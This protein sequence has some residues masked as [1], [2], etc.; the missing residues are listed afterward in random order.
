MSTTPVTLGPFEL[1]DVL[2]RGGMGVVYEAVHT[3]TG[4]SVAI[5]VMIGDRAADEQYRAD[6]RAE[7][8]AVAGLDHPGIVIVLDLGEVTEEA[9]A[10]MPGEL[11]EGS[12]W[13]A[14]E[15]ASMGTLHEVAR[16]LPWPQLRRTL[17]GLLDA[18][19]HAHSRGIVHRDMKPANVLL[20][21]RGHA[22]SI[23]A[24]GRSWDGAVR[25]TDFGLAH[26]GEGRSE[27]GN[28]ELTTA[29]TPQYMA[30]E[31]FKGHW[32]DYGPWTDLYA[33]GC[34]AWELA[35][36]RL[37]FRGDS[38][39]ALAYAHTLGDR[40]EWPAELSDRLPPGLHGWIAKLM[41]REPGDRFQRA[42]DAAWALTRLEVPEELWE[43]LPPTGRE[44][45]SSVATLAPIG[46]TFF[47][48]RS[49]TSSPGSDL[50]DALGLG[51]AAA[52]GAAAALGGA[53]ARIETVV[54]DLDFLDEP[55][56]ATDGLP[57]MPPSWRRPVATRPS[58]KL[59]GAGLGL[60]GLRAIPMVGRRAA[61]DQLWGALAD[62]RQTGR[63]RV[64]LLHGPAGTGK[65]RLAGW[66]GR[67]AEEVGAATLLRAAHGPIPGADHGAEA[68]LC[69]YLRCVGMDRGELAERLA[70]M[71]AAAGRADDGEAREL[72]DLLSPD[73][74]GPTSLR[75][76]TA[77]REALARTVSRIAS[78]RPV[79]LI[80]DDVAYSAESIALAERLAG[81]G[82]PV[83]VL[84]T[85]RDEALAGR[86]TETAALDALLRLD[87]T[88]R[89]E[90][91]PL[92]EG[93][94]QQLVT[95]LLGFRTGLAAAIDDRTGGNPLFCTA[96]IGDWVARG[97][98]VPGET[99]FELR[100]GAD[101]RL[102]DDLYELASARL[103]RITDGLDAASD[104]ALEA[105][106]ALGV[107][108]DTGE[109]TQVCLD[110]ELTAP[111]GSLL[112]RLLDGA[113]AH[114]T[115]RGWAFANAMLPESL[116]RRARETGGWP[117]LNLACAEMLATS[118]GPAALPERVGLHL[119]AADELEAAL[120]PLLEGARRCQGRSDPRGALALLERRG[121]AE[122]VLGL[123][124][125]DERRAEG[126]AVRAWAHRALGELDRAE[127]LAAR[128]E[129]AAPGGPSAA[130]AA[131]VRAQVAHARGD[132]D[133]SRQEHQ[134]A[135]LLCRDAGLE[136]EATQAIQGLADLALRGGRA[137][138]A[139]A[140]FERAGALFARLGQTVLEADCLRAQALATLRLGDPAD[141]TERLREALR[142]YEAAGNRRGMAD[143]LNSLA[144]IAR[145]QG[146]L[147][148]AEDGYR[149]ALGLHQATGVGG[150]LARINLGLV[151]L[152]QE[153]FPEAARVLASTL[154]LLG[155]GGRRA[156]VACA[157]AATVACRAA[158]RDWS[159]FD[160][161]LDRART[162]LRE[163]DTSER[164]VAVVVEQAGR[165]AAN[166]GEAERAAEAWALAIEQWRALGDTDRAARLEAERATL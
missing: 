108:V 101:D 39:F 29:G 41:A 132:F 113:L 42:A 5:K 91:G 109:W 3:P 148:D 79:V 62:V 31:Q 60:Y 150:E 44:H 164:D 81:T 145:K 73:P 140:L 129:D 56:G 57:P 1:R 52:V 100:P 72:L 2:G 13:M 103:A 18:L 87:R 99:G 151:L 93:D 118:A 111:L 30:P 121:G 47:V 61:R 96:L 165:I 11:V 76:A 115:P 66:L 94:R 10:A 50:A 59:V 136:Q 133:R 134:R 20:G 63:P 45:H 58:T 89:I 37:P 123:S 83:L 12:P 139:L 34:M 158:E 36:G 7:V 48:T 21:G 128:V 116:E 27:A 26:A 35:L 43:D 155:G 142:R 130:R 160:A 22:G 153:R 162:G 149:Q 104:E 82:A 84:M 77:R 25:L 68:A 122:R 163:T 125:R 154:E 110:R 117:A 75:D 14:M 64:L 97:V 127:V 92:A 71:L 114:P 80:L 24:G 46:E 40:P 6:F 88:S 124:D 16:P 69:R 23:R 144:E 141:A 107:Q 15:L 131:L 120:A 53:T 85:A 4:V 54:D 28:T 105:A 49:P 152:A 32:R 98:L 106:A 135:R 157:E 74:D 146:L 156:V 119:L 86:P 70:E 166:A 8:R 33:L 55:D 159:E 143:C 95:E 51:P 78:A 17:L 102:P 147:A 67:R 138:E 161:T 126:L 65:S 9:A 90:V 19:A 38:L 137:R 112:E